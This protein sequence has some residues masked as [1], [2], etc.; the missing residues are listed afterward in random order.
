MEKQKSPVSLSKAFLDACAA[1]AEASKK[2]GAGHKNIEYFLADATLLADVHVVSG[3]KSLVATIHLGSLHNQEETAN[4]Q[5]VRRCG[6]PEEAPRFLVQLLT[7][8]SY[9]LDLNHDPAV[10]AAIHAVEDAVF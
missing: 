2:H 8:V 6:L 9:L 10:Q 4:A 1:M 5:S 7:S 3:R